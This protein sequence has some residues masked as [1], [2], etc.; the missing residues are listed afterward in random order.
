MGENN[1]GRGVLP[2][3]R[4]Q[5][6]VNEIIRRHTVTITELARQFGV[7][8]MTI[9]RD[10]HELEKT[11]LIESVHGGAKSASIS[12]FELSY[13]QR[14]LMEMDAKRAIG[15]AA[16]ALVEQGDVIALD[17]S[18]TTL[19]VARNLVD[20]GGLTVYTNGIKVATELAHR[21]GIRIILT[22]GELYHSVSLVGL[23]ARAIFEKIRVDKLFLSVTGITED[24]GLSGPSD[25]DA[26]VKASMIA[27]ANQ[28][29]LVAD[30]TKFGRKSYVR[31][32]PL[33]ALH[34]VVTDELCPLEYLRVMEGMGIRVIVAAMDAKV[35]AGAAL[36]APSTSH[37][38]D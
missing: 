20:R 32:A 3:A 35:Q 26:D 9:R 23:F 27:A 17:G 2:S 29:I 16:A 4:G 38:A 13:A 36:E 21:P 22:G 1:G 12:P 11:G 14:E 15:H 33:N 6:I 24:L 18:T 19:Q 30:H 5:S 10:L 34:V 31:V 8:E 25:V 28:V 37:L 7:S